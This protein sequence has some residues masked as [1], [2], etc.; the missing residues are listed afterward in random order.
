MAWQV[1]VSDEFA[2]WY[3]SLLQDERAS[4]AS[5]VDLLESF[6]PELGRPLVDTLRESRFQNLKE[7]RIQHRGRPF[8]VLFVFDPRRSAYL[9]LGGDRTGKKNW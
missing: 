9:I 1:E 4:V 8:R 3:R 2:A 7:R 6:G 5:G